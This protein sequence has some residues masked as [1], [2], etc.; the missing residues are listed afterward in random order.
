MV[1][2]CCVCNECKPDVEHWMGQLVCSCCRDALEDCMDDDM[3][4][5][6]VQEQGHD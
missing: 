4:P 2:V 1:D 6:E 5:D 3:F